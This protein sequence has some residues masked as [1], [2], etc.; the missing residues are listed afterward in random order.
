LSETDHEAQLSLKD[1]INF[2]YLLANQ[3]LTVQKS[4][5]VADT[6]IASNREIREA[7]KCLVHLIPNSWKDKAF[8]KDLKKAE[9]TEQIDMRPH[10]CGLSASVKFCEELGLTPYKEKVSFDYYKVFQACID[11]LQRKQM[12]TKIQRVEKLEGII[13]EELEDAAILEG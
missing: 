7:I 13:F 5:L 2:P 4:I 1:R 9:I 11:L 12:L 8:E 3:I 10:F 6:S